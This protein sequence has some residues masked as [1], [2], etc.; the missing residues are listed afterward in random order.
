MDEKINNADLL[1]VRFDAKHSDMAYIRCTSCNESNPITSEYQTFC[2]A[3]N[4]KLEPNYHSWLLTH[5]GK[6]FQDFVNYC[7]FR[8]DRSQS[9]VPASSPHQGASARQVAYR[10]QEPMAIAGFVL[11]LVSILFLGFITGIL[12]IIF[13]A[14]GLQKINREPELFSGKGLAVAGLILGIIN[15]AL[16]LL[17]VLFA[18]SIFQGFSLFF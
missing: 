4:A 11:G 6:T 14:L 15:V 2:R 13:S 10:P 5:P 17:A 1:T 12:A 9:P 16:P 3:C 18:I 7:E 8:D